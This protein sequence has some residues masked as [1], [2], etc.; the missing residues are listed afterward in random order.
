MHVTWTAITGAAWWR[1]RL[2]R[3][4]LTG[5][6]MD[7]RFYGL[8]ALTVVLH[9]LWNALGDEWL[10]LEAFLLGGVAWLVVCGLVQ[11]GLSQIREEQIRLQPAL[12]LE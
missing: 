3:T 9:T 6:L 5:R 10:L 11:Q 2:D 1:A 4:D 8:L 7:K 12:N